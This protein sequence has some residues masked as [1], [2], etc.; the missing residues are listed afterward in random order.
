MYETVGEV[1]SVKDTAGLVC[2]P[3]I[4]IV[5]FDHRDTVY[6][7]KGSSTQTVNKTVLL[8]QK[9]ENRIILIHFKRGF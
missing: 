6:D 5:V 8:S 7:K 3:P 4:V 2:Q 9:L 1:H